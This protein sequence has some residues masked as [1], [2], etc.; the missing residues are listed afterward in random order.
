[1]ISLYNGKIQVDTEKTQ[2]WIDL[3]NTKSIEEA[4]AFSRGMA[5]KMQ[6][7]DEQWIPRFAWNEQNWIE[8]RFLNR[9]DLDRISTKHPVIAI[10]ECGNVVAVNT[11]ALEKLDFLNADPD[12]GKV[13]IERDAKGRPTG[14]LKDALK[15]TENLK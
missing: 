14:I 1:M 11:R 5:R 3:E 12:D 4:I 6:L 10:R 15:P 9:D 13:V 8:K 7:K 2:K